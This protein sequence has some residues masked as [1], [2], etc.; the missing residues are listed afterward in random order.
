MPFSTKER[1]AEHNKQY[2]DTNKPMLTIRRIIKLNQKTITQKTYEL[3][4]DFVEDDLFWDKVS[5]RKTIQQTTN[6]MVQT[7]VPVVA[8][9]TTT[10]GRTTRNK[11]TNT[12]Q[13]NTP[14]VNGPTVSMTKT[15]YPVQLARDFILANPVLQTR[16][17]YKSRINVLIKLLCKKQDDFMCIYKKES[18]GLIKKKYKNPDQYFNFMLYM[19]D[20]VP[21][22]KKRVD[23]NIVKELRKAA[24]ETKTISDANTIRT[25]I[26]RQKNTD[27]DDEYEKL[28]SKDTSKLN[29]MEKLIR[30]FY[31][32][33]IYGNQKTKPLRM[34]PRNYLFEAKII[35]T[36]RENDKVGN[37]YIE[38]T[39]TLLINDFKTK[40]RYEPITYNIAT[41]VK[42]QISKSLKKH[43]RDYLFGD[44]E[45]N[46]FN[47]ILSKSLGT[48]IDHY[49]RIMRAHHLKDG[50]YSLEEIATAMKNSPTSGVISY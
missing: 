46:D 4:K 43:P 13:V 2:K 1:K 25:N 42:Q 23:A 12:P 22:I 18:F 14:Q 31:I 27:Y 33:G 41:V 11:P 40:T 6:E 45:R 28:V 39:G 30:Q 3:I 32:Y 5:V 50:K 17:T 47:K 26:A 15:T 24:T 44:Y 49:R 48:G 35:K 21:E 9:P 34:I 16:K 10:V 8:Q 29:D 7:M 37:F 38:K 19:I 20:N 36:Q